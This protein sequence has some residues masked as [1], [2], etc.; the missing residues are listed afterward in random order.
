MIFL[1][2]TIFI[3]SFYSK[4]F[5]IFNLEEIYKDLFLVCYNVNFQCSP[6]HIKNERQ[7]QILI[8]KSLIV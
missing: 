1:Q 2:K 7:K 3:F 4:Y 6:L 8:A 5:I